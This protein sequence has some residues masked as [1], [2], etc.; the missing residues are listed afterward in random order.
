MSKA[1]NTFYFGSVDN[2]VKYDKKDI[3]KC[4]ILKSNSSR[5]V[6][7]GYAVIKIEFNNGTIL[8]IP[9]LLID[10][11]ALEDKLFQC[12]RVRKDETSYL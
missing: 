12:R 6:Y 8:T 9:N 7:K 4:T 5:S 11:R 3:L 2:M 1:N 10:H